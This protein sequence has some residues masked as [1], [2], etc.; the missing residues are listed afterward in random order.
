MPRGKHLQAA[1]PG[2]CT[3]DDVRTALRKKYRALHSPKEMKAILQSN[4]HHTRHYP[5]DT[6][7]D[8]M[9]WRAVETRYRNALAES[10]KEAKEARY[11]IGGHMLD[12]YEAMEQI[13]I[14][15]SEGMSLP[16]VV[17]SDPGFPPITEIRKWETRHPGFRDDLKAAEESRGEFLNAERKRLVMGASPLDENGRCNAQILKLQAQVLAEDAAF[18]NP[19][20]Q[21]K[22]LHQYEDVGESVSRKEAMEELKRLLEGNPELRKIMTDVD[23]VIEGEIVR[24]TLTE[25]APSE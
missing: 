14:R 13:V 4:E 10:K 3:R 6:K 12:R 11:R 21:P 17:R 19:R 23:E 9:Q 5:E 7:Q 25:E 16:E 22:S 24:D 18:A 1:N 8:L 20:F 2:A 15:V